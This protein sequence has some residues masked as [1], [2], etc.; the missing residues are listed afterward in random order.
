MSRP[1]PS[2]PEFRPRGGFY[3][4]L[5]R[6]GAPALV[7][8]WRS[9][10]VVDRCRELLAAFLRGDG[11]ALGI[12]ALRLG[13]GD[14]AWDEGA[15]PPTDRGDQ[16]LVDGAPFEIALDET[17]FEYLDAAG[18]PVAGPTPRLRLTVTLDP[19]QPPIPGGE[20]SYPL[21]EFGL[22]ARLDGE[23]YMINSVR[24]PVI[25]KQAEDTLERTIE[26]A[27]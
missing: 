23:D 1:H 16:A 18:N 17:D 14:A 13:R 21:R 24:H 15:P 2:T 4:R 5:L 3:D 7:P 20:T 27:L 10:L 19:G 12:H 25:H 11:G 22:F 8:G 26:L 9:N 6:P